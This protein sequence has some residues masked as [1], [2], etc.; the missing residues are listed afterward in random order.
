M[1]TLG[2][3]SSKELTNFV[4][5]S[6]ELPTWWQASRGDRWPHPKATVLTPDK[7]W[8]H[9]AVF[10]LESIIND[11]QKGDSKFYWEAFGNLRASHGK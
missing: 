10:I 9:R 2:S 5:S 1:L 8:L 7:G 3:L 6:E 4:L 11:P